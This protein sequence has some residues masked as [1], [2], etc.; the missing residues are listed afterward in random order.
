MTVYKMPIET[1][2]TRS[3]THVQQYLIL[4]STLTPS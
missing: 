1:A 4:S 3:H 2:F